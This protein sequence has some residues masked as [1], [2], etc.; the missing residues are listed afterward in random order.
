MLS[1]S[2]LRAGLAT[3]EVPAFLRRLACVLLGLAAAQ[4][5][6]AQGSNRLEDIRANVL[7][8]NKVE[9]TLR[10]S[11]TAP[12]PLTFT[13]DNPAR[14]AL[15]LPDTSVAM[16]S[17]RIDVKQ[18]ALDTVN[19]AEANGRTRVVLNVD[20]LVPYETRVQGNSITVTLAPGRSGSINSPSATAQA[21]APTRPAAGVSGIR[22]VNNIDFRRGSDGSGRV[23][24]ELTDAK[25]PAD[26]RQEGGRIVVNFAKTTLP[27]ALMQ[28]LDVVDFAT[29]VNSVDALRVGD[30]TRLV[31]A[32]T[33]DYEQLAY[34]SDNVYTIEVKP[35]VKLPPEL[36]EKKEY[37]GERLT[38]NFQDIETRAV[39]QLLADTSGQNMVISDTVSGNVTLRLQNVPWDQALD[40]VMRT[41]GLDMRREGN[42]ML[43][44]PAAEIAAREKEILAARKEVQELAPLRSEFLQVNYAKAGDLAALIKSG[45]NNSLLS[46]RGS[47]TIDERTNTLL[48]QDTS[49]R[50]ADIRRLVATLDIPVRQVRIEARIVIVNDDFSRDLGVRFGVNAT[51][52][53]VGGSDGQGFISNRG[54]DAPDTAVLF[55]GAND[56]RGGLAIG[57]AAERYMVNLPVANP[58]GA[59]ALTFLDSDF[60]VD[61]ELSA[62][63]AEGRG[64]IVSQPTLVTANQREAS[65]EQGV[66]I[67][68]QESSS[69]GATTTT[70]KKAVLSLKVTPQITPDNRVI[71]DLV[72]AKDS[73][74]QVV[75]SATGGFVPS[76]DTRE[77]TTQVLVNDGQTVVLGGILETERRDVEQK[78]PWLGDIP[79]LGYLFK[80]TSKTDNKDELL[81]F[82]TPRILREGTN[83]Y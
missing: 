38:L 72:V 45:N 66:E 10:L 55:P 16:S 32:A 37:T 75:P 42:V 79:G 18:G 17:R 51:T 1:L 76:I 11:D 22:A 81:I 78:V 49:D 77:I 35:V 71:L 69:S 73:V 2:S 41:K 14:I 26:L 54:L 74:G 28:R 52:T 29:P 15:D 59:L 56:P 83:L 60:I 31:I 30:G 53:D 19:V 44:G 57:E 68:Y 63:Q 13:V 80:S 12:Q 40:I 8:G 9:V 27:E 7:A 36:Q 24:V 25:V 23:I 67:P 3:A 48:L 82:V 58:A 21:V 61:L 50:L 5:A 70:F 6:L 64:E 62:A 46:P 65:I 43:V 34:Q 33:G 39:L 4:S 20:S 47:V